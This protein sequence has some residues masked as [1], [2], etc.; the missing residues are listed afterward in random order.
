MANSSSLHFFLLFIALFSVSSLSAAPDAPKPKTQSIIIPVKKDPAT[1]QYYSSLG[2]GTPR[3]DMDLV[4]DLA[5]EHLW[6]NCDTGYNSS[7]YIPVACGS[8]Q[9][10]ESSPCVGCN[11]FPLKPGCTNNTCGLDVFNPFAEFIFSGDMGDDVLFLPQM[12]VPHFLSGCSDGDRFSSSFLVGLVKSARGMVGLAR[13]ELALQTQLSSAFNLPNKFSLCLPSSKENGSGNIFIG[14]VPNQKPLHFSTPL[15]INPVSTAPSFSEGEPSD[16]YFIG[17]KSIKIDGKVVNFKRSLLSI[18][19]K[20][21]GGTKIS[22]MKPYTELHSNIYKSFVRQFVK[23]AADRKIKRVASVAPFEA[24]FDAKTIGRT[25][26]G[27]AVPAIDLELQNEGVKWRIYG[28]NSMVETGKNVVCLGF[29]D[30]G[31]SPRTS[32]VIGGHQLEDNVL[33]FDLVSSKLGFS[34][35]L[36]LQNA[37]CSSFRG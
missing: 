27:P 33:E 22:T 4:I 12:E 15:V 19:E 31:K 34:S 14:G 8:K 13:T 10:P 9:C 24:C 6:Y 35:S 25:I 32:V 26:A 1:N 30:G 3:H 28:A 5:G 29:V 7:S 2:I 21:N 17:V 20:G 23:Q 18:D 16:E 36:L 11:N 37:S